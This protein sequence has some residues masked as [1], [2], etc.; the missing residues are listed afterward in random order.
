MLGL[1]LNDVSKRG[2]GFVKFLRGSLSTLYRFG[3][4]HK[5]PWLIGTANGLGLGWPIAHSRDVYGCWETPV[6]PSSYITIS[7][8]YCCHLGVSYKWCLR[9]EWNN[10]FCSFRHSAVSWCW[11]SFTLTNIA[12]YHDSMEMSHVKFI[13]FSLQKEPCACHFI[14][15]W[16]HKLQFINFREMCSFY[17]IFKTIY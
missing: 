2:P 7:L 14:Q 12:W 5:Q 4:R 15:W 1:K 11:V 8:D 16:G 13:L 9:I 17:F 3:N 6:T 10:E